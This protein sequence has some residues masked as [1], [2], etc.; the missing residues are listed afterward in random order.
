MSL[1]LFSGWRPVWLMG[2]AWLFGGLVALQFRAQAFGV[3]LPVWL[4][5]SSWRAPATT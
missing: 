5:P 1:V 3:A 4:L 2:G